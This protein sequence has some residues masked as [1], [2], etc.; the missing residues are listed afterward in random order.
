MLASSRPMPPTIAA[1]PHL[2]DASREQVEAFINDLAERAAKDRD[3]L[4][5]QLNSYSKSQEVAP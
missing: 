3:G 1:P 4:I 5:C 2:R